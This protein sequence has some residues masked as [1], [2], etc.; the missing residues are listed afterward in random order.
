MSAVLVTGANGFVARG[1]CPRLQE[2]GFFV[3]GVVRRRFDSERRRIPDELVEIG[4]LGARPDWTQALSGIN[5]VV[6]LAARVHQMRDLDADPLRAFRTINVTATADL[7]RQAAGAGVGRLVFLSTVKVNGERTGVRPFDSGSQ[8]APSDPYAISKFEAEQRLVEISRDTGLEVVIVRSPL[9]YGPGVGGNFLR[10]L[11]LVERGVPLPLASVHNR[12]S[13]IGIGNLAKLICHCLSYPGAAG[14]I[15]LASDGEDLSTP[16]L[17]RGLASAMEKPARLFPVPTALL[18]AT[19]AIAGKA[20]E[21][22]R[23]TDSL[24]VDAS[25]LQRQ[26]DWQPPLSVEQGLRDTVRWYLASRGRSTHG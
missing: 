16:Q 26:L 19:A 14:R 21:L 20:A 4:D 17:I 6:H 7:A 18:T 1:L 12:R 5:T 3:R 24:Q 23:L 25:E 15:L 10:L 13:M 8:S 11:G 2:Q 9:V 22:G